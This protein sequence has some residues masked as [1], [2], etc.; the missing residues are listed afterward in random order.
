MISFSKIESSLIRKLSIISG[1]VNL[2][3]V[4]KIKQESIWVNMR[5][6]DVYLKRFRVMSRFQ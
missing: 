2:C 4:I 6:L 1:C 3:W 5:A